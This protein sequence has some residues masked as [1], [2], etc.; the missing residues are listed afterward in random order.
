MKNY[1]KISIAL[2]SL[3]ALIGFSFVI[4]NNY[5][6]KTSFK[7]DAGNAS[8]AEAQKAEAAPQDE[9]AAAVNKNAENPVKTQIDS[10]VLKVLPSDIIYGDK[11]SPVVMIEY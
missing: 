4:V 1:Q 5:K 2:I 11:S 9:V 3:C 7:H 10:E 6:T 8:N